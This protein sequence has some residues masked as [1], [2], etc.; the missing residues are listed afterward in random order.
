ML[1]KYAIIS[2]KIGKIPIFMWFVLIIF[3]R[4]ILWVMFFLNMQIFRWNHQKPCF[5]KVGSQITGFIAVYFQIFESF[6][7]LV[8]E[9]CIILKD[10]VEVWIYSIFNLKFS[11]IFKANNLIYVFIIFYCQI[12]NTNSVKF[13]ENLENNCI[14]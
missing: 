3:L 8:F 11:H 6:S 4:I 7:L 1:R 14:W 10:T 12:F 2:S 5:F 9:I 13:L